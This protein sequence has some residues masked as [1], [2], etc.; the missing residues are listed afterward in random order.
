[1]ARVPADKLYILEERA[2][3]VFERLARGYSQADVARMLGVHESVVSRIVSETDRGF[4]NLV[5]SINTEHTQ[6][7]Q[8]NGGGAGEG[9]GDDGGH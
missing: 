6:H 7:G 1:M 9:A 8:G 2:K 5:S 4:A 3:I